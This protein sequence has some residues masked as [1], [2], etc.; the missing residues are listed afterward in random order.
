M[1]VTMR[2]WG[3]VL[4]AVVAMT[5]A[6]VVTAPTVAAPTQASSSVQQVRSVQAQKKAQKKAPKF[7]EYVSLGDSWT[8]AVKILDANGLPATKGVPLDCAQSQVN[9]PH[10]IA[11]AFKIR[12]FR[13]ASCGSATSDHFYKP[14][15]GLPLGGTNPPQFNRLTKKTDLVT[16]GIG[17]NDIGLAGS[18]IGCL[19]A[20]AILGN[21]PLPVP[22][23]GGCAKDLTRGGVDVMSRNIKKAQP[24]IVKALR[25]IKRKAPKARV[26]VIDYLMIVPNHG[27][28]PLV[29]ATT[30]DV[31]YL[32][33]K[34][35]ELN[36]ML[37]RAARQA[38]VEFVKTAPVAK[39]H[40]LCKG[41]TKRYGEILGLTLNAPAIGI[42][43]H[44]NSAGAKAQSKVIIK[45]L[46][47]HPVAP[48]R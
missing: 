23:T 31:R 45:Y 30:P 10:L 17:G 48:K 19:N 12:T 16:V 13:D 26:L 27:C 28:W 3:G 22:A 39:G 11:K 42:P 2:P 38:K 37:R 20:L 36:A 41:M 7:R 44:P 25:T 18:A 8:A 14:Q 15:K 46:R 33:A 32:R 34:L 47:K 40:E 1:R 43:M 6:L 21:I 4:A 9:Y 24:K 35:M 5:G 29:P